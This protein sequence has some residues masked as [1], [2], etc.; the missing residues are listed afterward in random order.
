[1]SQVTEIDMSSGSVHTGKVAGKDSTQVLPAPSDSGSGF[2]PT[3]LPDSGAAKMR[4]PPSFPNAFTTLRG[5]RPSSTTSRAAPGAGACVIGPQPEAEPVPYEGAGREEYLR[6]I[7]GILPG[8][9]CSY[10][11]RADGTGCFPYASPNLHEICGVTPRE[12]LDDAGAFFRLVHP[13]DIELLRR[14]IA[15]CA[16]TMSAGNAE[17]RLLHPRKGEIWVEGR[18]APEGM[19]DGSILMHGFICDVTERR[20]DRESLRLSTTVF[21][22]TCEGIV[23]T[24]PGGSI[25]AINPAFRL[26]TGYEDAELIGRN[27]RVLQSGRQDPAFYDRMWRSIGADGCWQGEIWNRRKSGEVYSQ[28]LT[29]TAV[30]DGRG[31]L[32]NYVGT[33][34]DTTRLRRSETRLAY[35]SHHDVLTDLPNRSH[36]MAR[37]DRAVAGEGRGAVLLLDLDRFKNVNDSLGHVAGDELLV[38]VARRLRERLRGADLLTR[39]GGDEFA[40]VV[41]DAGDVEGVAA[42][43]ESLIALFESP[44]PIA[45]RTE[46]YVGLSVGISLFP[47][48]GNLADILVQHADAALHQAK[49]AGRGTFRFYDETLTHAASDR[50]EMEG[51]LRRALERNEFV[52]YY[53]PLI[54]LLDGRVKGFEAL[55]RWQHP[56][57]GLVSPDKFIPLAEETGLIVPL[58]EWIMREAC[59]RMKDLVEAGHRLDVMAVNLSPRQLL[60]P[61]IHQ[62]V[63]AILAEVGLP[64]RY[65]ELEITEG[66]LMLK[67]ET[68]VAKLESLK[69]LGIS[70]AI[71][72]FGTGYSSLSYLQRF[73]I[74]KLKIDRSFIRDIPDDS[75]SM[76]IAAAIIGLARILSLEVVAEGVETGVQLE[77]VRQ[78]GCDCAQGYLFSPPVSGERIADILRTGVGGTVGLP[79]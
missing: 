58:G 7:A 73:P 41:E 4:K 51:Q 68:A 32:T 43:A 28:W 74:D 26:I 5:H 24:D 15:T 56:L 69:A 9:V 16:A 14:I 53:Q 2:V 75:T 60:R 8:A 22:H 40:V 55:V 39:L 64:A 30:H 49:E 37:L 45:Q 46:V 12:V 34:S 77:F 20:R 76:E 18:F 36:L 25:I 65:L 61:D 48:D 70:L 1:M 23:V 29:I 13:D 62:K 63:G 57:L 50:L 78:R 17:Y 71:D 27:M 31:L 3:D 42:L 10:R 21:D 52:L 67:G 79:R 47:R 44:F 11:H 6:R 54:S 72:D 35:L 38:L 19:P 33:F 59:S 66:A